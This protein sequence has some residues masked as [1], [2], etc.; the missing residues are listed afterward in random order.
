M[1]RTVFFVTPRLSCNVIVRNIVTKDLL[2]NFDITK[3][4]ASRR[5]E[6]DPFAGAQ[7]HILREIGFCSRQ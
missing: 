7:D 4:H 6:A 2:F 3:C 5:D 1:K